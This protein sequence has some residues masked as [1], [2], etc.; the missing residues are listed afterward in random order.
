MPPLRAGQ[1]LDEGF[2]GWSEGGGEVVGAWDWSGAVPWF[3]SGGHLGA[4][5]GS[6]AV[7]M[8]CDRVLDEPVG[9]EVEELTT[10]TEAA[11]TT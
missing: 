8:E 6:E 1:A 5:P 11:G 2:R 9:E 7:A 10:G 3:A 4:R